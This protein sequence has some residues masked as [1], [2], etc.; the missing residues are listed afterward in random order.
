MNQFYDTFLFV[1]LELDSPSLP[2]WQYVEKSVW[3]LQSIFFF[4]SFEESHS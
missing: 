1:F 4:C 3:T 2:L